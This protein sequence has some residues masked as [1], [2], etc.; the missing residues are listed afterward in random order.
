[1]TTSH[2]I[3]LPTSVLQAGY[4]YTFRVRSI[5]STGNSAVSEISEFRTKGYTVR[6]KIVDKTTLVPLENVEVIFTQEKISKKTDNNGVVVYEDIAQLDQPLKVS[7]GDKIYIDTIVKV[8]GESGIG[9][10]NAQE[11]EIKVA[12]I[13]QQRQTYRNIGWAMILVGIVA[14]IGVGVVWLKNRK[15]ITP[16]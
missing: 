11:V 5:D 4:G 14:L 7:F 10:A 1:M 16:I 9:T 13:A 8:T 6:L 3:I 12:G 15:K 2:S